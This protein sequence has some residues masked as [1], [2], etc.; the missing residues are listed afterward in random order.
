MKNHRFINFALNQADSI[1]CP[2]SSS[3]AKVSRFSKD[4]KS[5]KIDIGVGIDSKLAVTLICLAVLVKISCF[6]LLL[7]MQK[8]LNL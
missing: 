7:C 4:F 8:V 2:F 6:N 1:N 3:F 5:R